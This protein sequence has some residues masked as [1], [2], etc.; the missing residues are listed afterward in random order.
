VA[1]HFHVPTIAGH[2]PTFGFAP[3]A[4][5]DM[6]VSVADSGDR[7]RRHRNPFTPCRAAMGGI[8]TIRSCCASAASYCLPDRSLPPSW[9][10]CRTTRRATAILMLAAYGVRRIQ[11]QVCSRPSAR[12]G[13]YGKRQ[14]TFTRQHP[15]RRELGPLIV[16]TLGGNIED[17]S[18]HLDPVDRRWFG[19]VV[20]MLLAAVSGRMAGVLLL[21]D[22]FGQVR[23]LLPFAFARA[24]S[25]RAQALFLQ[26]T[27][28][29]V[30]SRRV[31]RPFRR[32]PRCATLSRIGP[33]VTMIVNN[34][35]IPN[36]PWPPH[37]SITGDRAKL[38]S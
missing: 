10:A 7:G 6:T 33:A 24:G 26:G 23:R 15:L 13:N 20:R 38:R 37:R 1:G 16:V 8:C 9:R 27:V 3:A 4:A 35:V 17:R 12:S 34:A 28:A 2:S 36:S 14:R 30:A 32:S 19:I 21:A 25:A 31:L 18:S 22:L 11:K 5:N 29:V